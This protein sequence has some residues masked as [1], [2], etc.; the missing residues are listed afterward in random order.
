MGL[1]GHLAVGFDLEARTADLLEAER[2]R[3]YSER[4]DFYYYFFKDS[5]AP[6]K[7]S[8]GVRASFS[9]PSMLIWLIKMH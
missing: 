5:K 4:A 6:L 2:N 8:P 9:L 1:C 3:L 7:P